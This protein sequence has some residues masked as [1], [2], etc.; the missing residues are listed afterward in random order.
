MGHAD[1]LGVAAMLLIAHV[2]RAQ[3]IP[4]TIGAAEAEAASLPRD[5]TPLVLPAAYLSGSFGGSLERRCVEATRTTSWP[6]S[7]RSGEMIVRGYYGLRAG[8]TGNKMLWM[9]LH[10][11]GRNPATLVIRG[12]RL[13]HPADTLRETI[14]T[15]RG[16]ARQAGRPSSFGF[17]STVVFP[18]P[19]R[20]LVV[21]D[22]NHDWG[23]FI[24]DVADS[25]KD[26][27]D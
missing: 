13:D 3:Q 12:S 16:P 8:K 24:L 18:V 14:A 20:W 27:S 19:G 21:A 22:D 1:V 4:A 11:P 5:P 17:P 10:D 9:P 26:G 2:G 7:L 25:V 6:A 23:C 15:R